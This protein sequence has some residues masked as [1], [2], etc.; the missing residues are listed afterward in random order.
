[1]H[2]LDN[3]LQDTYLF[4]YPLEG[5]V[6]ANNM[7]V[8]CWWDYSITY[9]ILAVCADHYN[10]QNRH[11]PRSPRTLGHPY[12]SA[13]AHAPPP[14]GPAPRRPPGPAPAGGAMQ[15]Y[16]PSNPIAPAG[17]ATASLRSRSLPRLPLFLGKRS[18]IRLRSLEDHARDEGNGG[19]GVGS[20][21]SGGGGTGGSGG[22]GDD[23]T[24]RNSSSNVRSSSH[25]RSSGGTEFYRV[26]GSQHQRMTPDR[27]ELPLGLPQSQA[28]S[29]ASADHLSAV[30]SVLSGG[31]NS[32]GSASNGGNN[33]G[34][35]ASGG[36]S[37]PAAADNS[38][39]GVGGG[40]GSGV[41]GSS[42]VADASK[43][44]VMT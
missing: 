13:P 17:P 18:P 2:T 44:S 1:M 35:G 10:E 23:I 39:T 25:L 11:S 37:G 15:Q 7:C 14:R 3:L 27:R 4:T 12:A 29:L 26:M 5:Y 21:G 40:S 31:G 20:V 6:G 34:G 22:G 19:G 33:G 28:V 38:T 24:T 41:G 32:G 36:A 8:G 43:H 9:I 42:N 30:L 16:N